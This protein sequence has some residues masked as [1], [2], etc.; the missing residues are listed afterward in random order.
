MSDAR[1]VLSQ[2]SESNWLKGRD[3]EGKVVR[4]KIESVEIGKQKGKDGK[5]RPQYILHFVGTEKQM[6]LNVGNTERLI[7]IH[8][9]DDTGWPG[10]E[11]IL[12][13][14]P[15]KNP[16]GE[17]VP[18]IKIKSTEQEQ[19]TT[20]GDPIEHQPMASKEE[21]EQVNLDDIPF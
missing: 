12:Y 1:E 7:D 20:L 3:I 18:G 11:I 15:V 17:S 13:T 2:M 21:Q 19:V 6:G 10:K 16:S 14:E 9:W 8:G 5:E 4:V